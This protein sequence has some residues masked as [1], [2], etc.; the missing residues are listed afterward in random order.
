MINI[1][2]EEDYKL[3]FSE[4]DDLIN[5]IEENILSLEENPK[6]GSKYV[7]N[8]F[9]AYHTLK[10]LTAMVNL[11]NLSS[12]THQFENFMDKN[13]DYEN[14]VQ[15]KGSFIDL[16]FSSLDIIKNTIAGVKSNKIKDLSSALLKKFIDKFE[17]FKD[18]DEEETFFNPIALESVKKM[19]ED[20]KNNFY[21]IFIQIQSACVFKKV[22]L[23]IIFRALN[24]IGKIITSKPE[25]FQ[26]EQGDFDL[27]F[28]VYFASAKSAQEIIKVINE[29][30][31]IERK[32]VKKVSPQEFLKLIDSFY[33]NLDLK[34]L[35]PKHISKKKDVVVNNEIDESSIFS[36]NDS[37]DLEGKIT[38]VKIDIEVLEQ[39]MDYFG[40]L[41]IVKNQLSQLIQE[42]QGWGVN[43]FFDSMD[44]LFLEIQ[45]IIFK[46]KLIRVDSKFRRYKRL[47]RDIARET[48]K[49]INFYLEGTDVEIDRKILEQI[50]TPL[51]HLLRNAVYHGIEAPEDRL[52]SGK[53]QSGN[54]ILR[55]SRRASSILI[56]VIDDGSGIDYE[57]IKKKLIV[58][59]KYSAEEVDRLSIEDLNKELFSPGFSTLAG[60]DM[61]SGRGMGLA[62]VLKKIRELG[63]NIEVYSREKN[64]TTFVLTVPFTR[65]ILKAQLVKI[66]D[67]LFAIP[68]ENIQQIYF[69]DTKLVEYVKGSEYYRLGQRLIPI[70]RLRQYLN[71]GDSG[72]GKKNSRIAIE[73][74]KDEHQSAIFIVDEILQQMEL[75][76]K[77]FISKFSK[78]KDILGTT[79][80][81]D[82]SICLI[83]DVLNIMSAQ[84]NQE[85]EEIPEEIKIVEG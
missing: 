49:K 54:L 69:F 72:N 48:N 26:L 7:K 55:T 77:P 68:I 81:G 79:I 38:S 31:E 53:E 82:G 6:E 78:F 66:S 19:A 36:F 16:L 57:K 4:T 20:K 63:G 42:K 52:R 15:N 39:L 74:V 14:V 50:N 84:K 23:F 5:S 35:V 67:D 34:S 2:S 1:A 44:K 62:I 8:L 30:L 60:A 65:A 32:E 21:K 22:R 24:G 18:D 70:I 27:S 56:E 29:I 85:L 28:E 45:E 46:L 25:P 33:K 59:G 9:F 43:R 12:F 17:S 64:G 71:L 76:I 75:V 37:I 10:G 40:E 3:F 83:I 80:T 41:V 61:I 51:I 73:C 58:K 11:N 13:K 47:V